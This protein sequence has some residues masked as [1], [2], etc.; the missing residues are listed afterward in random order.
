MP[1]KT[2]ADTLKFYGSVT[3]AAVLG[4]IGPWLEP[5][6]K[7]KLISDYFQPWVNTAASAFAAL[8]FLVAFGYLRGKGREKL[9]RIGK[10]FLFLV[11]IGF[12]VCLS[13]KFVLGLVWAPERIGTVIAWIVWILSYVLFFV[14]LAVTLCIAAFLAE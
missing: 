4:P 2:F 7:L 8:A 6:L 1:N 3:L 12:I 11:A 9:K 10:V 13:L 14:S 5:Y